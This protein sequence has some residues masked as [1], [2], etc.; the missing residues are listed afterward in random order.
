MVT[1]NCSDKRTVPINSYL[2]LGGGY[3]WKTQGKTASCPRQT[4]IR[5]TLSTMTGAIF[6]MVSRVH[7]KVMFLNWKI[8]NVDT[9]RYLDWGWFVQQWNWSLFARWAGRELDNDTNDS[10]RLGVQTKRASRHWPASR[11]VHLFY[12]NN[13]LSFS[14]CSL[15]IL[16][17][18]GMESEHWKPNFFEELFQLSQTVFHLSRCKTCNSRPMPTVAIPEETAW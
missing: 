6:V 7:V 13:L 3:P 18:R 17:A 9:I 2:I 14:C 16:I 12:E 8:N 1:Y 10:R 11:D 15:I 4:R 5:F